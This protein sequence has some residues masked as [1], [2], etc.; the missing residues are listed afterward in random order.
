MP[1]DVVDAELLRENLIQIVM[2][3][4]GTRVMRPSFGVDA[5]TLIGENTGERLRLSLESAVRQAIA[6]YEPRV[7]VT[8][9]DVQEAESEVMCTITYVITS[10]KETDEV[11]ISVPSA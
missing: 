11:S 4:Q 2:T 9:V 5:Y 1:A 7:I 6:Q 10:T 8:A 3:P